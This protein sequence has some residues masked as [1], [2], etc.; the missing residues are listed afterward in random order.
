MEKI[1][2]TP[3]KMKENTEGEAAWQE[4]DESDM[5]LGQLCVY[6]NRKR[7]VELYR[8]GCS[9]QEI[10]RVTGMGPGMVSRLWKKCCAINPETGM[11]RGYQALVPRSK[12]KSFIR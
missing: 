9:S 7:A 5:N 10:F 12:V 1:P 11:I 2:K 4:A 8:L 3:D 6:R